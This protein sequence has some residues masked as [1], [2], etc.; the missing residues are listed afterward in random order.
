MNGCPRQN[1]AYRPTLF[2]EIIYLMSSAIH[3]PV[4]LRESTTQLVTN[5]DGNYIDATF[6]R[7]GHMEGI[8]A[9]LNEK[10]K[11]FAFDRDPASK[12]QFEETFSQESR[13]SF[14]QRKF[15]EIYGSMQVSLHKLAMTLASNYSI[16][17]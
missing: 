16:G 9:L 15:S 14:S 2:L 1:P 12:S 13:L 11:A 8:L 5:R 7:G 6:G 10:G 4:L 17:F 3:T